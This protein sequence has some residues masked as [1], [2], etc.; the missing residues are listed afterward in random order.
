MRYCKTA[1]VILFLSAMP[2]FSQGQTSELSVAAKQRKIGIL[3][4]A[5]GGKP[6]WNDEVRKITATVDKSYPTE[7]AFGMASRRTIQAAADKL[8]ERGATEIVSVP[9]FISSNSSVITSTEYLLGLRKEMPSDLK[10]FA[11]MDH[12]GGNGHD[13]HNQPADSIDATAPIKSNLPIVMAPALND[14]TIA[15]EILLTR[16]NDISRDP[17]SEVVILVAHGPVSEESNQA[18]LSDMASLA[19]K[20]RKHSNFKE[21]RY[22]TV[23][24]DAPEPIR[25]KA[26]EELRLEVKRAIDGNSQ[27]LIVPLLISYG[28]IEEGIKKRLDGL[29]YVLAKQAL[30]PDERLVQWVLVSAETV[31]GVKP[32]V[33]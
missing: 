7:V 28:G 15:A 14:H 25:S 20:M 26:T 22:L 4:L 33:K 29:G 8:K 27:A 17:K 5:H 23:R 2:V 9:L 32:S 16:A 10:I 6:A 24:D 1:L 19:N 18:W 11:K 21:I 30:L 13:S 3:L 31:A 12:G